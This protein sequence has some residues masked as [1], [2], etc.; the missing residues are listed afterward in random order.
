MAHRIGTAESPSP[1]RPAI[2]RIT[3]HL[4][5]VLGAVGSVGACGEGSAQRPGRAAVPDTPN[6]E[7]VVIDSEDYAYSLE[8]GLR[9]SSG[10]CVRVR[11]LANEPFEN[12]FP[13]KGVWVRVSA[14]A[15]GRSPLH[16]RDSGSFTA[17]Q[18]ESRIGVNLHPQIID[19]NILL[20]ISA[21]GSPI[22]WQFETDAGI[23]ESG[24]LGCE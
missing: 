10:T 24:S 17:D 18:S 2:G 11:L 8:V 16:L 15:E 19:R 4:L 22:Q 21:N 23:T 20:V 14:E 3:L 9:T 5:V 1:Q 13:K 6:P 7:P 12:A